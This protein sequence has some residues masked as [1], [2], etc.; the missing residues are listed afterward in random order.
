VAEGAAELGGE[1]PLE[2]NLDGL[3]GVSYV[4]GCYIGQELTSRTHF[5]G[6]VRKRVVPFALPRG[7]HAARGDALLRADAPD[8]PP[9]GRVIAFLP[10]DGSDD[11]AGVGLALVRLDVLGADGSARLVLLGNEARVQRPAWWP[12]EWTVGST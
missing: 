10:N 2:C 3:N 12:A 6:V 7:V 1:L 8:G 5:R 4:K 9:A 11:G